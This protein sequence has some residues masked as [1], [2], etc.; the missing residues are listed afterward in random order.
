MDLGPQ[1]LNRDGL[2]GPNS[3]IVVHMDPLGSFQHVPDPMQDGMLFHAIEEG[4]C[5][6][7]AT[8]SARSLQVSKP[9]AKADL[10]AKPE[11][12]EKTINEAPRP[13]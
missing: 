9:R 10:Q 2:L 11:L 4:A 6:V 8:T 3:I 13:F 7:A 1:N 12:K 5:S